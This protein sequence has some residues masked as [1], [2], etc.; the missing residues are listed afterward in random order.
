MYEAIH[1]SPPRFNWFIKLFPIYN[2]LKDNSQVRMN[3]AIG[4]SIGA[5]TLVYEIIAIFGYLTFGSK[6]N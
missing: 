3:T 4:G 2:E 1:F 5:A 6:V